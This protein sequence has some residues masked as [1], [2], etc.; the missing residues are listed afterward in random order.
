MREYFP[1][2]WTS[3]ARLSSSIDVSMFARL[4]FAELKA[5]A[6]LRALLLRSALSACVAR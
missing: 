6:C 3:M 5:A 1:R 4:D 2:L